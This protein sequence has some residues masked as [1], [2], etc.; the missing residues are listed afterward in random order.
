MMMAIIC[1]NQVIGLKK[2]GVYDRS[3]IIANVLLCVYVPK[4]GPQY[5]Y[6]CENILSG[7][8]KEKR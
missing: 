3:A 6:K 7:G 2:I 4:G 1:G 5:C 8:Q